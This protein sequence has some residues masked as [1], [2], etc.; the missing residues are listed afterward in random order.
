[1]KGSE[2]PEKTGCSCPYCD[3]ELLMEPAP[4]C[5]RCQVELRYCLDCGIVV[6]RQAK[7]CPQ[8]GRTLE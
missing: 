6:E 8:C 4:F 7:V 5:Q 1:M 2:K 3:E